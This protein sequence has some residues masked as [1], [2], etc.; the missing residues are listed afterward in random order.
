MEKRT[1]DIDEILSY[2]REWL[3]DKEDIKVGHNIKYDIKFL[4]STLGFN[5]FENNQDT[6]VGWYLAVTQETTD[7]KR[8]SDLA[9]EVTDMGGYDTPLEEFKKWFSRKLLKFLS[10]KM[11]TIIKDNKSIAK[12][13][14]ILKQ[15][16]IKIGYLKTLVW[17][18]K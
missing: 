16:N 4:M 15:Q 7:S 1:K 11:S 17:I 18:K 2:L 9:Y 6:L 12:K 8:L 5:T 13:N 10:E 3:A 14:I